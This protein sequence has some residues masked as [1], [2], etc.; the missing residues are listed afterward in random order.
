M[1]I[2]FSY[3]TIAHEMQE[4]HISSVLK[5]SHDFHWFVLLP[6]IGIKSKL[7]AL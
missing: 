7:T 4:M 2:R 5:A 3:L 6:A 1:L